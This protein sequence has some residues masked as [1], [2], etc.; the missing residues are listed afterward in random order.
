MY[1]PTYKDISV[2]CSTFSYETIDVVESKLER[3]RLVESGAS[4]SQ[5]AVLCEGTEGC[6]GFR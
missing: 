5:C 1:F 4:L 6:D 3:I 2:L